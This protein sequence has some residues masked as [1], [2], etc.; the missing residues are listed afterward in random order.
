MDKDI[1]IYLDEKENIFYISS[2][3]GIAVNSKEVEENIRI[4]YDE[5]G[6]V[7][8]IRFITFPKL[9]N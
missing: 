7:I 4:E 8:G 2:K 3:P 5:N 9:L 6:T 1:K